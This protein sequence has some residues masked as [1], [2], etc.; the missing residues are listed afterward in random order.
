MGWCDNSSVKN[1]G[2]WVCKN[3]AGSDW[4]E[5]GYIK[6]PYGEVNIDGYVFSYGGYNPGYT[7]KQITTSP[8][9]EANPRWSPDGN[10][11][12]FVSD[13]SGE[14]RVWTMP[15]VFP[16]MWTIWTI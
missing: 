16:F 12:A 3:S 8:S 13:R 7:F 9:S 15:N 1:G 10:T 2:Y 4:G 5:N 11:I 14:R 6:I